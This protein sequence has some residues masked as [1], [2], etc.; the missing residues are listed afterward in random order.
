MPSTASPAKLAQKARFFDYRFTDFN[1]VCH[2]VTVPLASAAEFNKVLKGKKNF[3]GSS[4]PG[5]RGIEDSDMQLQPDAASAFMDPFMDE[6]TAAIFCNVLLPD[7]SPYPLCPRSIAAKA[8]QY[9]KKTGVGADALF[10]PEP[11]FFVFDSVQ[12]N[13]QMHATSYRI[14]SEE[15][16]WASA[17][18]MEGGN[19]GHRPKVKG[20]YFPLPPVDQLADVRNEMCNKISEL[21]V[22]VEVHHHEV[23]TAGQCEIGTGA[24]SLVRR[25]DYNQLMKYAIHNVAHQFGKTATFMPKPLV[26]DNGNGMH[27]HQS[28]VKNGKNIFTGKKYGGLSQEA[29][30][31][32]GGIIRHARALNAITNPSTNSYKRLM[33]GYEAPVKLAY[34]A[35]NRSASIRI[36]LSSDAARRIE[37][38]F[39]DPMAN[40]YM[41][42]AALLL[43]GLDGIK[44]K[45][46][47][48]EPSD[49]NL[50]HA[51]RRS[52]DGGKQI[53]EVCGTLNEAL[54][55]LDKDRAFLTKT[56][57][58]T[59]ETID[60]YLALKWEDVE[61]FRQAPH[62][63]EFD[64]YYSR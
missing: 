33:P 15:G 26:G 11:E 28:I 48:G 13:T 61:R 30:W 2:H 41:C 39:P 53:D 51:R 62:P 14:H 57:V 50:Y 55:A 24:A 29:L 36:P 59:D 16:A 1:G 58:F 12:W 32:I 63:V 9:L 64:M 22:P 54:H 23:A 31:Y 3:D 7:N 37:T 4:I 6:P 60:S 49:F 27:V 20:G 43:A 47:P 56:G 10:G 19:T 44:N 8:V 46:D 38:R 35:R 40:P 18:D 17:D 52:R 25:G 5:W 42:F 34:S 21:G 45:I